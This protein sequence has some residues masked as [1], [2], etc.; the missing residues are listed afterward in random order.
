MPNPNLQNPTLQLS[1]AE[2]DPEFDPQLP[3]LLDDI[4]EEDPLEELEELGDA[5]EDKPPEGGGSIRALPSA[6]TKQPWREA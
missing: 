4:D 1:D 2:G 5:V 6:P 3:S